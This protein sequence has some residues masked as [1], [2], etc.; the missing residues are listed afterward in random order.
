LFGECHLTRQISDLLT[1]AGFAI[2]EIDEFYEQCAPKIMGAD[3]LRVAQAAQPT[4][5]SRAS[6][7]ERKT[8]T[9]ERHP[10]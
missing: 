7:R 4:G 2:T 1:K 5:R 10:R 8:T 3:S 6:R 9:Q